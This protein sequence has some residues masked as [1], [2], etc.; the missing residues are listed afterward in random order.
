[1]TPPSTRTTVRDHD[2]P[3]DSSS[4][5]SLSEIMAEIQK[6]GW[7]KKKQMSEITVLNGRINKIDEV[8]K[9]LSNTIENFNGSDP[10]KF[11]V[12]NRLGTQKEVLFELRLNLRAREE[13]QI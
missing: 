6:I 5:P 12:S 11:L 8:V 9:Q 7:H 1:M 2:D 3:S 13:N 10:I 4:E